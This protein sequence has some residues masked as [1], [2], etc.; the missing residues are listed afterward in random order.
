MRIIIFGGTTEGNEAALRLYME[1]HEV[2]VSVA[3]ET[4]A[5]ALEEYLSRIIKDGNCP[6]GKTETSAGIKT[7]VG[8]RELSEL[9]SLT[10]AF[11]ICVDATHPFAERITGNL[12]EACDQTGVRYIRLLREKT[13]PLP[14]GTQAVWAEGPEEAAEYVRTYIGNEKG[15]VLLTTGSKELDRYAGIPEKE[16]LFA[17]VLPAVSSIEACLLAGIPQRNIIAAWGPFSQELN[18]A[19]LRQFDIGMLVTKE[20]GREGGFFDK[21]Q[22]ARTEGCRLVIIKRPP[23]EGIF[24]EELIRLVLDTEAETQS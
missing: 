15:N 16:R 5:R 12:R 4:G 1:G 19:L 18:R 9:K 6:G 11:D 10:A 14:A 3:T 2:T 8:R 22:A 13:E 7:V 23:E 21:V 20:S 24:F 17:R